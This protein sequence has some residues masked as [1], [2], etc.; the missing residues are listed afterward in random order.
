MSQMCRLPN[1]NNRAPSNSLFKVPSKKFCKKILYDWA[2]SLEKIILGFRED[3][4]I[5][6]LFQWD[7]SKFVN[8]TFVTRILRQVS[9]GY[10]KIKNLYTLFSMWEQYTDCEISNGNDNFFSKFLQYLKNCKSYSCLLV[11]IFF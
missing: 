7:R 9:Y 1:C 4:D 8:V 6:S 2:V 10:F 11:V 3:E 5:K